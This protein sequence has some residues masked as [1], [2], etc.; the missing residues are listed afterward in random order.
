MSKNG[1]K[2]L[3]GAAIG[4]GLGILLAPKSGKETRAELKAK[5]DELMERINETNLDEV[6]ENVKKKISEI[7][8]DLMNL[9]KET[10][11][12][13][14]KEK[15]KLIEAKLEDLIVMAGKAAKPHIE[16]IAAEAKTKTIKT[17]DNTIKKLEDAK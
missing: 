8:T 12:K 11:L 10:A 2:F 9:D 7:E 1:G 14:A 16:K 3:L 6:K 13:K 5:F 17:L 15:A 4:I